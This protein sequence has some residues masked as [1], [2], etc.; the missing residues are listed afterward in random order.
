MKLSTTPRPAAPTFH[1]EF[2][3]LFDQFTR[4][5]FFGTP[6]PKFEMLWSPSLDFSE[7]EKEYLVRLEVPGIP[8]DDLE[9][10]LDGRILT[11]SGRREVAKEESNEDF[12][13]R[14]R[15]QGRFVRSV[16]LPASVD[17]ARVNAVCADGVMTVHLPKAE[18]AVKS[19]IPVK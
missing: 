18:P 4:A 16:N 6:D 2:D 8:R 17:P 10:N 7:T 13:W 5:G 1:S 3:R 14:E 9:V 12:F 11:I 19:R 15:E